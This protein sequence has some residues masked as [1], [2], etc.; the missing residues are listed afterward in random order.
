M[1]GGVPDPDPADVA[2]GAA[3]RRR[4]EAAG[5]SQH[6]VAAQLGVL[7]TVYS[8]IERGTRPCRATELRS[9]AAALGAEPGSLLIAATPWTLDQLLDGARAAFARAVRA[10]DEAAHAAQR[11]V[12]EADRTGDARDAADL[13]AVIVR[14]HAL[15]PP[16][17][18][19]AATHALTGAVHS[20]ARHPGGD[21]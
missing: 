4:R 2:L 20:A 10:L 5:L 14:D 19:G 12:D 6:E 9:I 16:W 13:L 3:I 17:A 7:N 21:G 1:F 8:R 18:V 15:T 11:A